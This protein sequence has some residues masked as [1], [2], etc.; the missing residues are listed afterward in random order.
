[1]QFE[2]GY[3]TETAA[4]AI[5]EA[6]GP[7]ASRIPRINRLVYTNAGTEH[8]LTFMKCVGTTTI[9]G[10]TPSG[11]TGMSV[12]SI[13][14]GRNSTGVPENLTTSDYVGFLDKYGAF[15]VG[16]VSSVSGNDL[17]LSAGVG[18][19][20]PNGAIL[21]AFYEV[22]R[23]CHTQLKLPLSV[24]T[25]VEGPFQAG[26]PPQRGAAVSNDGL[27]MPMLLHIDNITAAGK[28]MYL[29]GTYVTSSNESRF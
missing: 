5:L 8:T 15:R 6:I 13:S 22:G 1:M 3:H 18:E 12:A 14:P 7:V 2:R 11:Q 28:L 10:A 23:A 17:T 29:N 9:I 24:T 4:T 26:I 27:G 20:I 16:V 21:Y 25:T 19:D